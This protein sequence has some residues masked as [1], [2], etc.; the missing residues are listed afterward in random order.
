[1]CVYV[2]SVCVCECAV[3]VCMYEPLHVYIPG[4]PSP[5]AVAPSP[6]ICKWNIIKI[7]RDNLLAMGT[8]QHVYSGHHRDDTV[9]PH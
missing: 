7:Y 8:G 2:C 6:P 4:A 1:M 9:G 3:C 5:I